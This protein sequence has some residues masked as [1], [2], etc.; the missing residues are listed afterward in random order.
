[1]IGTTLSHYEILESLGVGGMGEVYLARDRRLD[2]RVALKLLPS[3]AAP[4]A[5]GGERFEREARLL[6]S[7]NHPNIVTLHSVETAD[8][9]RFLTME[10]V[11]GESLAERL[12]T[13]RRLPLSEIFAFGIPLAEAVAAAHAKGITHRDLKPQNVM[14][15]EDGRVKVL[16]FGLAKLLEPDETTLGSAQAETRVREAAS[17][18]ADGTV[19]GTFPYMSPEQ[20]EGKP[21]D[22]RTDLF[23]LG[24]V[25]FEMA[26]GRRPFQGESSAA[27]ASSIL[28]DEPPAVGEINPELPG[29]LGRIIRLCLEK[30][31]DRRLQS[32]LDL[33]NELEALQREVE[34]A[35]SGA[36]SVAQDSPRARLQ[37]IVLRAVVG[38]LLLV[39]LGLL[40]WWLGGDRTGDRPRR[41][42]S[43]AV[44]PFVN[45]SQDAAIDYL[46]LAIPDEVTTAL[47][48]VSNLSIRPFSSTSGLRSAE[49]D[50]R[51]VGSEL[52]ATNIVTGQYYRELDQLHLTLEAIAVEDNRVLWRE[53][54]S[55]AFDDVLMLRSELVGHVRDGLLPRLG[56]TQAEDG[57]RPT[58]EEAYELYMRSLALSR[59]SG[60]N[61]L[62]SEMLRESITLDPEYAPAWAELSNRLNSVA[63][64]ELADLDLARRIY[65]ESES[66]AREALRL[67]PGLVR[68]GGRLVVLE[69]ERGK[70]EEAYDL[71]ADLVRRRPDSAEAH[72]A[73]SYVLRYAG[74][75][76]EAMT[77]CEIARGIDPTHYRWR[78]CALTFSLA[79][80]YERAREYLELDRGSEWVRDNAVVLALRE[81]KPE[82]ARAILQYGG[83]NPWYRQYLRACLNDVALEERASL[84]EATVDVYLNLVDPEHHHW[85]GSLMAYC[86][87]HESALG[88]LRLGVERGYCSY[89]AIDTDPLLEPLRGSAELAEVR[90]A[91][92]ACR[93]RFVAAMR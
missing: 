80:R 53:G 7:L 5:T 84:V 83:M 20:V 10:L 29:H 41:Q 88:L 36:M 63:N 39:G 17:L 2:R 92:I 34:Q 60:S 57:T 75:L 43:I 82:A 42:P 35:E 79:G 89:P 78:S 54:L 12:K 55:V 38:A 58:N 18:T 27:L 91:G 48:R 13:R 73:K 56:I 14:I 21:V 22:H 59:D 87:E 86:G 26:T 1:M 70:L 90:A 11:E 33:R 9:R 6:A 19:L 52:G 28:R 16:D 74:L 24:I 15:T 72:F 8:D 51:A 37:P 85:L 23:S 64:Y 68:A 67:D 45:L 69:T 65:D 61:Q 31:P 47:S 40:A 32:A 62:A 93:E 44:L 4:E 77:E 71:A 46:E 76:D 30:D 50:A 3:S 49:V 25:L 66:A 81:G